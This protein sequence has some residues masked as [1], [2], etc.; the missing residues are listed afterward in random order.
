MWLMTKLVLPLWT[1]WLENSCLR[2]MVHLL[3]ICMIMQMELY[4][5][6]ML[7]LLPRYRLICSPSNSKPLHQKTPPPEKSEYIQIVVVWWIDVLL[8]NP[9][10]LHIRA[11]MCSTAISNLMVALDILYWNT[12]A[13]RKNHTKKFWWNGTGRHRPL[14]NCRGAEW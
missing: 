14:C 6:S 10:V 9:C 3:F 1:Y 4:A 12:E 7:P 5:I 8:S 2:K 11:L 13:P